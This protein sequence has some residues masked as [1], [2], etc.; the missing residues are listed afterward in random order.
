MCDLLCIS[1]INKGTNNNNFC[2]KYE[3]RTDEVRCPLPEHLARLCL[4]NLTAPCTS[5]PPGPS[6]LAGQQLELCLDTQEPDR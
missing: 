5:T 3:K 6:G 2:K 4:P 1:S